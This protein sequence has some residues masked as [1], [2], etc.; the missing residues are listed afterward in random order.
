M[1]SRRKT[2]RAQHAAE[3]AYGR[4][5][6]L[7][8][9]ENVCGT[10]CLSAERVREVREL[11]AP[12]RHTRGAHHWIVGAS[13][14]SSALALAGWE[15]ARRVMRHGKDGADLAL[16]AVLD[17]DVTSRYS[18]VVVYSGDGTFADA[19]A[20]LAAHGID[21]TV[22]A[23]PEQLSTRLRLAAHH[24]VLLPSLTAASGTNLAA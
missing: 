1:P 15:N 9:V 14:S 22:V 10:G 23:R 3:L 5:L 8:D 24:V 7:V 2:R 18:H 6:H 19:L 4:T 17:E 12:H 13:S 16:L 21:T 20:R 11:L